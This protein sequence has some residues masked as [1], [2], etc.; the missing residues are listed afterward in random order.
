MDIKK[1]KANLKLLSSNKAK[2]RFAIVEN[3]NFAIDN[4]NASGD[5]TLLTMLCLSDC[6]E[7]AERGLINS[8]FVNNTNASLRIG[9]DKLDRSIIKVIFK[10]ETTRTIVIKDKAV[11]IY[12]LV[13]KLKK[14]SAFT[15]DA[16]IKTLKGLITKATNNNV[17][18]AQAL[19][20][21]KA[22][23]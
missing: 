17:D 18:F 7:Q 5:T 11:T 13:D 14:E 23:A 4:T 12:T 22:I 8:W 6:L 3:L 15:E 19:T 1:F 21:A 10:D 2:R 9:K 20:K 16:L